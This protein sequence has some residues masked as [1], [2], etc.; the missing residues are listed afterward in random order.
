MR[1]INDNC[2]NY[3][4]GAF[5]TRIPSGLGRLYFLTLET[6]FRYREKGR[7]Q[8]E[9]EAKSARCCEAAEGCSPGLQ[10]VT[11][12]WLRTNSPTLK[13]EHSGAAKTAFTCGTPGHLTP[14]KPCAQEAGQGAEGC[15]MSTC[16][17]GS[18]SSLPE[19]HRPL[20]VTTLNL[21]LLS[22]SRKQ[23]PYTQTVCP[24]SVITDVVCIEVDTPVKP[25]LKPFLTPSPQRK[26]S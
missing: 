7:E 13:V 21:G 15:T 8:D 2:L 26:E 16:P 20:Q 4:Q 19:S 18:P 11:G 22:M 14:F 12:V 9:D 24:E 10:R 17:H 6:G 1:R 5:E 25:S 23:E 3:N